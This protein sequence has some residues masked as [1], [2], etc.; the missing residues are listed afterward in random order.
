MGTVPPDSARQT[1]LLVFVAVSAAIMA[2]AMPPM[3]LAVGIGTLVV[4]AVHRR[5]K[6][7]VPRP[8]AIVATTAGVFAVLV[9]GFFSL[10]LAMLGT[11][12]A[13]F[14]ECLAGANTR[15]AQEVCQDEFADV[16]RNRVLR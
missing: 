15:V 10:V 2:F 13:A 8:A 3:G 4:L 16:V 1:R 5:R 11:E 7:M 9:G 12:M 14:R 6:T